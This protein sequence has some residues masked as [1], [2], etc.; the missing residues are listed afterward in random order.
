MS[1][2]L[3][4]VMHGCSSTRN[5]N[6]GKKGKGRR[7][8]EKRSIV[9]PRWANYSRMNKQEFRRNKKK[10]EKKKEKVN[11]TNVFLGL[12]ELLIRK[13]GLTAKEEKKTKSRGSFRR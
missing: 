8:K 11:L 1:N 5:E 10:K 4:S 9:L 3:E 13:S 12:A 2:R 6:K 7:K